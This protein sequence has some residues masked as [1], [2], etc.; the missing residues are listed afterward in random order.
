MIAEEACSIEIDKLIRP[1]GKQD[2][3]IAAFGGFTCFTFAPGGSVSIAPLAISS[4]TLHDLEEH[5]LMFFTGYSRDAENMLE[6][7][8]IRSEAG[9]AAMIANLHFVKSVGIASKESLEAGDTHR[10]ASLMHEHWER[11]R[12]RSVGMTN[13]MIDRWYERGMNNGALGGKLV[14]AGAGG[15]LLFYAE[16]TSLLRKA[17]ADEGLA[18]VRFNFDYDGSVVLARG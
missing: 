5:L 16:D 3:Y 10:F 11:K 1:V 7:Q 9:D 18:E 12:E 14:G 4:D 6:D 15:F 2:Q 13:D 17:M 8:K